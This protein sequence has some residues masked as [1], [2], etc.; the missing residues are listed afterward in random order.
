MHREKGYT[1]QGKYAPNTSFCSLPRLLHILIIILPIFDD[2]LFYLL[3]CIIDSQAGREGFTNE[4]DDVGDLRVADEREQDGR[5]N[6]AG[7]AWGG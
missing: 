3:S 2:H 1:V 6:V 7:G 4:D 5:A